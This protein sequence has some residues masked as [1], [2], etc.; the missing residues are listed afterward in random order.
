L[1]E[2]ATSDEVCLDINFCVNPQCHLFPLPPRNFS[3]LKIDYKEILLKNLKEVKKIPNFAYKYRKTW[4]GI[5][6]IGL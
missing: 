6:G 2:D 4:I 3:P 5:P 1:E